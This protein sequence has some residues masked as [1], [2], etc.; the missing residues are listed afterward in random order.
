KMELF[1]DGAS[2]GET[3]ID[4]LALESTGN[5]KFELGGKYSLQALIDNIEI[6]AKPL[7][8]DYSP[9][10]DA[11]DQEVVQF[12]STDITQ[13]N[14][15]Y[16]QT[17]TFEQAIEDAAVIM[18]PIS[19]EGLHGSNVRIRNVTDTGFEFQ[20]D[21]W[22]YL[23][24][25]HV[26]ETVSWMAGSI[27]TH[28]LEDGSAVQFGKADVNDTEKRHVELT[29]F[30]DKPAIFAQLTGDQEG[31]ALTHRL[32]DV[33][34]AGFDFRLQTEESANEINNLEDEHLYWAAY[35]VAEDSDIFAFGSDSIDHNL[36]DIDLALDES[37]AFFADMQ[38][39]H[40]G[41]TAA[42]R[43]DTS[44]NGLSLLIEE[45]R[46]ANDEIDHTQEAVSWFSINEGVYEIG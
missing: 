37:M 4:G 13:T 17:V 45:E 8:V 28:I 16:W 20:V 31:H 18:G 27:G 29:G 42:V 25:R 2:V 7:Y 11:A 10:P 14:S 6:T 1:L 12:G 41:D 9:E 44:Q 39:M 30:D 15:D 26:T 40:G 43:Y 46:S 36:T 21:E 38:T 3:T 5:H 32:D 34:K 33:G 22:D 19:Y 23:D 24:G 35:D